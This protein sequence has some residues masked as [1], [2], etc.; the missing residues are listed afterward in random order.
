MPLTFTGYWIEVNRKLDADPELA[1]L[2]E[3]Y[4]KLTNGSAG[5]PACKRAERAYFDLRKVVGERAKQEVAAEEVDREREDK[6]AYMR[7]YRANKRAVR[8]AVDARRNV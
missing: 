3:R 4:E 1:R 2:R 6:A 7:E 5:T 8:E